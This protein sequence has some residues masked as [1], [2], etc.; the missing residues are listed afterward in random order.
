MAHGYSSAGA[1]VP[2]S[3]SPLWAPRR[4]GALGVATACRSLESGC[5][6]QGDGL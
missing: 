5:R 4:S 3:V 6:H 2:D 1:D